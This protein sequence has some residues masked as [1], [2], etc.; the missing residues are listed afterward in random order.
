MDPLEI[1]V[2]AAAQRLDA[3]AAWIDVRELEEWQRARIP[4]TTLAPMS[5]LDEDSLSSWSRSSG[6]LL[7]SCATGVRSLHVAR[8]LRSHGCPGAVSVAGGI[9]AWARAGYPVEGAE[10]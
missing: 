6:E 2:H 10:R 9:V 8:H 1:D 7:I 3:G 5:E 4:G